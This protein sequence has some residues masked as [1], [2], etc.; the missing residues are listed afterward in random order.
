MLRSRIWPTP[1]VAWHRKHARSVCDPFAGTCSVSR[2]LKQR[3]YRL[4]TGDVLSFV[5]NPNRDHCR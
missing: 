2:Y 4:S 3:G 5:R 1:S